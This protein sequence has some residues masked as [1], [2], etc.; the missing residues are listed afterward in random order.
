MSRDTKRPR[1]L[2]PSRAA[3]CLAG[4]N[5]DV[6]GQLLRDL[7]SGCCFL[8]ND[9]PEP[10]ERSGLTEFPSRAVTVEYELVAAAVQNEIARGGRQ[11]RPRD[12]G[13]KPSH[14]PKPFNGFVLDVDVLVVLLRPD[15]ECAFVH[16]AIRID[17]RGFANPGP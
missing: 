15:G 3:A 9:V 10:G 13:R 5:L 2:R 16:R 17:Q 7:R 11:L 8:E 4:T 6:R 14:P 12:I 1:L